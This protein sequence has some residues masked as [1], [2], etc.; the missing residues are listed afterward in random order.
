MPTHFRLLDIL[1]K[2]GVSQSELARRSGISLRTINRMCTNATA[3]VSL[4][5]LDALAEVLEVA[6]GDLIAKQ[7]TKAARKR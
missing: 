2:A 1:Q 4:A 7:A 5:T 3:Q 6:P